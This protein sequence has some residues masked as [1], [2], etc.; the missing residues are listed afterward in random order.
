[1]S[2]NRP[3]EIRPLSALPLLVSRILANDTHSTFTAYHLTVAAQS[4]NGGS[5]FH[6]HPPCCVIAAHPHGHILSNSPSSGAL[7]IDETSNAIEPV[8]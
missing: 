6:L 1:M 2:N 4:F 8:P 7:R 5:D 3:T